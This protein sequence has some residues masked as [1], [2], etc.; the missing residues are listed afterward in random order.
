MQ[1]FQNWQFEPLSFLLGLIL[2]IAGAYGF[3][4]LLPFLRR[5]YARLTGWVRERISYLRSGVAV[6]F[7]AET[8]VYANAH[9]LL[10]NQA[11]L[12]ALFVAPRLLAPLDCCL[13]IGGQRHSL[14]SGQSGPGA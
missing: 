4:R 12:S 2:G 1:Q 7:M 14:T 9:H 5:Q 3:L 13:K 11:E 10:K 6:R 8:A